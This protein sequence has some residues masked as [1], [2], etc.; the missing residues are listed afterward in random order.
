MIVSELQA[1]LDLYRKARNA[2]LN[3]QQSYSNNGR[4]VTRAQLS[5]VNAAI[6][7]LEMRLAVAKRGGA[8]ASSTPYFP[9]SL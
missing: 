1:E 5:E 6:S 9:G 4:T 7:D 2:I 8:F 3:G